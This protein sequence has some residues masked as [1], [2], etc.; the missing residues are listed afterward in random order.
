MTVKILIVEDDE[1]QAHL[2]RKALERMSLVEAVKSCHSGREAL[3][4]D[5]TNYDVVVV[6]LFM[7]GMSGDQVIAHAYEKWGELLPPVLI[8]TA[9]PMVLIDKISLPMPPTPIYQKIGGP[10]SIL[11]I[12]RSAVHEAFN[13]RA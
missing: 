3:E 4:V 10:E 9:S 13:R 2:Y 5:W 7:P 12:L 1:G 6:D 8:F 11:H